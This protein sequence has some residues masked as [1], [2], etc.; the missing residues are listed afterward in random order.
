MAGRKRARGGGGWER[1][2]T[3]VA[4]ERGV[5][6]V[7]RAELAV[8]EGR[9]RELEG[10][11]SEEERARS[12]RLARGRERFLAARGILRAILERYLGVDGARLRFRE[13]GR[14]GKPI[15]AGEFEGALRF[16]LSHSGGLALY[17]VSGEREVGV[18]VEEIRR[19]MEPERIAEQFFTRGELAALR[20]LGDEERMRAFYRCWTRKEAY[21]KATGRGLSVRLDSFEV[22]VAG[23]EEEAFEIEG[24]EGTR[25]RVEDLAVADGYAG[26]VGAEGTD[27]GVRRWTW[28]D[29]G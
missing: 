3:R 12:E 22:P 1:G 26:A 18:D 10:T 16:N 27:W 15:I 20:A 28:E 14:Y 29:A 7:W 9:L 23:T 2:S 21:L 17:A 4:L 6:D 13:E 25:W 19:D 8:G 5:V 11:L 24:A